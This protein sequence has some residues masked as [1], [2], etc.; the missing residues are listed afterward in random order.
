MGDR[1]D[2][3]VNADERDYLERN[4]TAFK[5]E[6]SKRF[7]QFESQMEKLSNARM[8][9]IEKDLERIRKDLNDNIY[10]RLNVAENKIGKLED[11]VEINEKSLESHVDD[12]KDSSKFR[13]ETALTIVGVG[14][15]LAIA[16]FF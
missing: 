5:D 11:R 10:N 3:G 13:V 8:Q 7:D 14:V 9:P 6:I 2:L 4:L 15:A 12:S 1:Q 16:I